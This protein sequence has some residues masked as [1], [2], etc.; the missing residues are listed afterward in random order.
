[1]SNSKAIAIREVT[2]SVWQM[3]QQIA[4]SIHKSR[5]F[6]VTSEEGAQTIML[7]GYELGLG[8]TSAFEFIAVI[9][10]KPSLIPRGALALVMQSGE[11]AGMKIEDKGDSCHVWMKRSNG[12]EYEVTYTM[13]D[14]RRAGVVKA[15]S[16]W[17]KYPANMLR[18]RTIGF[19]IDVLFPDI[20]GGMKRAD[21]LGAGVNETGDVIEGQWSA[22]APAAAPAITL[23]SL[24][25]RHGAEA[26]MNA[27]GGT[28]PGTQEDVERIAK[29]LSQ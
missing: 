10:G 9:G 25:E 3:I 5:M 13:D 21:E 15:D 12:M 6:G 22:P 18:W 27:N 1:M 8:L 11:L 7:K 2:P 17:E 29:T 24:V 16:G 20:T 19:C 23:E 14:A 4:P 28:I 26:V